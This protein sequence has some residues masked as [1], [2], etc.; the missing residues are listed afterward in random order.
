MGKN[1]PPVPAHQPGRYR[2]VTADFQQN[3]S[4]QLSP[5]LVAGRVAVGTDDLPNH[6]AK[7]PKSAAT[8][9]GVAPQFPTL[10]PLFLGF[11]GS[12]LGIL[13]PCLGMPP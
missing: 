3:L 12:K 4:G 8:A 1:H 13:P 2:V 6:R 11:L 10:T 5:P 7:T 9:H